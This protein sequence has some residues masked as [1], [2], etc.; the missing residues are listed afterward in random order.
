[1]VST[2]LLQSMAAACK[3]LTVVQHRLDALNSSCGWVALQ[4]NFFAVLDLTQ[5][6][7]PI[8]VKQRSGLVGAGLPLTHVLPAANTMA[9][10]TCTKPDDI[11]RLEDGVSPE[12]SS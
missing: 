10:C 11:G 5:A 4:V 1:M 8:M 7:A 6:V 3:V 12:R 9:W 2:C